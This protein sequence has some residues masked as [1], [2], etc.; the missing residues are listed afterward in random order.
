MSKSNVL[1]AIA[2]S[3]LVSVSALHA[4]AGA[5]TTATAVPATRFN[6][7]DT[8]PFEPDVIRGL[9]LGLEGLR[10]GTQATIEVP[11]DLAYGKEGVPS[12]GIPPD[13]T[14]VFTVELVSVR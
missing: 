7:A 11:P 1:A 12:A 6:S 10:E 13:E 2:A 9:A 4:Q 14:L 5:S 8:L 3:T